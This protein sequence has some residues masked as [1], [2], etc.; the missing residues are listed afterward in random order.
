MAAAARVLLTVHHATAA[1]VSMAPVQGV[2]AVVSANIKGAAKLLPKTARPAA[3]AATDKLHVQPAAVGD[4]HAV[5]TAMAMAPY[6]L[7]NMTLAK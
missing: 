3:A 1:A 5:A 7:K 6:L 4:E 2:T